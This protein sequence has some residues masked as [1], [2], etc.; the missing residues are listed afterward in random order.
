MSKKLTPEQKQICIDVINGLSVLVGSVAGSGKTTLALSITRLIYTRIDKQARI[1][2]TCFNKSVK[3]EMQERLALNGVF[4]TEANTLHS[5][6]LKVLK[7]N[8]KQIEID[9]YKLDKFPKEFI[10]RAKSIERYSKFRNKTFHS[11]LYHVRNIFEFARYNCSLDFDFEE[12]LKIYEDT[13]TEVNFEKFDRDDLEAFYTLFVDLYKERTITS[14]KIIVDFSDMIFLPIYLGLNFDMK[15]DYLIMDEVQDFNRLHHTFVRKIMSDSKVR[16]FIAVG[17]DKQSIYGFAGSNPRLFKS[18]LELPNTVQ[19]P[20]S[21]NF[22][23]GKLIINKANEVYNNL[24]TTTTNMGVVNNPAKIEDISKGSLVIARKIS[25]LL[26]G[27]FSLISMNMPVAIK[28][29]NVINTV[30]NILFSYRG[31]YIE[32]IIEDLKVA[33][34]EARDPTF[35]SREDYFKYTEHMSILLLITKYTNL[36]NLHKKEIVSRLKKLSES[37]DEDVITMCSI[38]KSKGLEADEVTILNINEI[39]LENARTPFQIEQ[40]MNL[41]YVA[42]T[43]AVNTLNLLFI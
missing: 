26:K 1:L 19:R 15:I 41:K 40:E 25:T 5:I 14:N 2:Y 42:L 21:Y 35:G 12:S 22:R 9:G 10:N 20:M 7:K 23:C 27:F 33:I 43:R 24:Q 38:H 36:S 29:E 31:E 18:F 30:N 3:E 11:Y 32:D 4:N 17:D 6:G 8:G 13:I 28:D 34:E 39:P 37:S 16:Q